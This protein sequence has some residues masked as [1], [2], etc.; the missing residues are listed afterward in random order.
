MQTL[1]K[2]KYFLRVVTVSTALETEEEV[3]QHVFHQSNITITD[4]MVQDD[5]LED[6]SILHDQLV[7]LLILFGW[8]CIH[9]IQCLC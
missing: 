3:R 5:V 1:K 7:K 6:I 8:I 4:S 9:V 2:L